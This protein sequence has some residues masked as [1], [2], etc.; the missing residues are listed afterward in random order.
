MM[1]GEPGDEPMSEREEVG[2]P[3]PENPCMCQC[4]ID[5]PGQEGRLPRECHECSTG[6]HRPK[7]PGKRV[8]RGTLGSSVYC[9]ECN[10]RLT[11]AR[12]NHS[13]N[14]GC[15]N[16]PVVIVFTRDPLPT[17]HEGR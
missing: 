2:C 4:H 3:S 9:P 8:Y 5:K 14:F 1:Q 13:A 7:F 12:V 10:E 17:P 16:C 15:V 6:R 11:M